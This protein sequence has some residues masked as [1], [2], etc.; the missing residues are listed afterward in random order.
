MTNTL[1]RNNYH[2]ELEE[3]IGFAKFNS[4]LDAWENRNEFLK[5][6]E[7][8][9]ATTNPL[10]SKEEVEESIA[11]LNRLVNHSGLCDDDKQTLMDCIK[12]V[13]QLFDNYGLAYAL[14]FV[15][16]NME[17]ALDKELERMK[18]NEQLEVKV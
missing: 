16:R 8:L 10:K 11:T 1:E 2:A 15:Q 17:Y 5:K 4:V 14:D 3:A 7:V 18:I 6:F 12:V 9:R 13:S